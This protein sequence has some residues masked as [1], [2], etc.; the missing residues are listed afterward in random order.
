MQILLDRAGFSSGEI[1]GRGGAN[2]NHAL[3]AFQQARGLP[4]TGKPDEATL[5]ALGDQDL[6]STVVDYTIQE[7]DVGGPFVAEIPSNLD[8]QANLQ[9]LAYTSPL[10]QLGE[11]FH[12]SPQLLK[13]WNPSSRLAAGESIKVPN[14][15]GDNN[16]SSQQTQTAQSQPQSQAQSDPA[17]KT[18]R[19]GEVQVIVSESDSGVRVLKD[20]KIVFF[21][22][23]TTGSTHEPLPLGT[24]KVTG[25]THN[26][27]FFYNPELFWDPNPQDA[28]ARIPPGPNNPVGIV[29]I[30]V[31]K[32][33]YGIHGSPE[34]AKIGHAES[35]GCVRMTNWDALKLAGMVRK[36]TTVVFEK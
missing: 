36:G 30:D 29:W 18:G 12:V 21:A 6:G 31:S 35:N 25:V 3:R 17:Q 28:K 23:V 8:E 27:V 7:A 19:P 14:I 16:G 5:Q 1:D 10:E 15:Y 2:F 33:H 32:E 11:H 4:D 9:E 26:P 13:R 24:W 22:P 34:P 20:G